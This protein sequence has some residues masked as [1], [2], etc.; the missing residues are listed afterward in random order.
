MTR[1]AIDREEVM[2][3]LDGALEPARSS[4]V[5]SHVATCEECRA[6]AGELRQVSERLSSWKIGDAPDA[7]RLK[8]IL[9]TSKAIDERATSW[10]LRRG[11][12]N[13]PRWAIGGGLAVLAG[14]LV[15]VP[16][17]NR[18]KDPVRFM[19]S[20]PHEVADAENRQAISTGS[21][22]PVRPGAAPPSPM[23]GQGQGVRAQ[24]QGG[25]G[26]PIV[27]GDRI[28]QPTA[29]AR[30]RMIVRTA[31][32]VLTSDRFDQ[33]R[34]ELERLVAAHQGRV[35]SLNMSGDPSSRRSL[36]ATVGVPAARLDALLAGLRGLGRVQEESLGS[37]DVTESFR[38]LTLRISNARREEQRLV[39]LL[40]RRTGDLADVLAVER[41]IA[42]VRLDIERM[43]GEMRAT[44]QRVDLA[45]V[46]LTVQ[47]QYRADLAIGP[48]PLNLRFKNALVDG[49]RHAAESLVGASLIILQAAPMLLVWSLILVWPVRWIWRRVRAV[50]IQ[51]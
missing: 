41:E 23:R 48:L 51:T 46:T 19:L 3:Y 30:D 45:T 1:H 50:V 17:V 24:G 14:V 42:R 39:E 2:A 25:G 16:L 29:Q 27:M 13:V 31:R 49:F 21:T 12:S 35:T 26:G 11:P 47:E 37:D 34:A 32:M 9:S 43:E 10:W 8:R 33:I 28:A 5:Q 6:F 36:Q 20:L 40:T 7:A 15:L 18:R 22:Q 4:V 44:E 38:D